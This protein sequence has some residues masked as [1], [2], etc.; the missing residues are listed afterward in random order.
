MTLTPV[1]KEKMKE[2]IEKK[3]EELNGLLY[4]YVKTSKERIILEIN[5]IPLVFEKVISYPVISLAE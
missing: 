3:I 5:T 4:T 1:E 2:K